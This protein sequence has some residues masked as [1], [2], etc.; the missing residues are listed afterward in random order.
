MQPD[1]HRG[2]RILV[3]E[4]DTSARDSIR[5]LL[6]IDRHAVTEA[7]D[8][9]E[10]LALAGAQAFDL[11]IL[12]YLMPGM[13]GGEVASRLR[14]IAPAVPILMVTAFSEK[15]RAADMP[16]VSAILGKPFAVEDLRNAVAKLVS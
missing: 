2:K 11:V 16:E 13:Q 3:V 1:K 9:S 14:Q 8:G 7:R 5:L 6:S 15:L 12:D 4:D 10:A